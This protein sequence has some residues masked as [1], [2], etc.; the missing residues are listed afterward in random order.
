MS[1]ETFQSS[2]HAKT[3]VLFLE[4]KV[5]G[6]KNIFL[7]IAKNV[8]HNKNGKEIYKID[9]GGQ[10]ILAENGKKIINDETPDI[11]KA[12]NS[13]L[14][15]NLMAESHLGFIVPEEN[16]IENIYI[17]EV[18]KPEV[19]EKI[20]KIKDSK[21]YELLKFGDLVNAKIIQIKR[22]NE[23]GSQ[24]YGT[25]N[26][27]FIRTTDIVNWEV[28]M[29]TVKSISEEIYQKYKIS[30]D[31]QENDILFVND[32]T[33]L[34]GR[35]SMVTKNDIKAVIQSHL[36]KIRVI[37]EERLNPHYLFYLL[38]TE[39][40]QAQINTKIFTQATLSTLGNRIMEI[41][42]PFHQNKD[43]I[44]DLSKEIES[45]INQKTILRE[46]MKKLADIT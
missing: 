7:A 29:D 30:Q 40:V 36:R 24:H 17:P 5:H 45:I 4:K 14:N 28:K 21:A 25:G 10:Y 13:F 26:I 32:G 27:P 33:F 41:E 9:S 6:R 19:Q 37:N 46:R 38:N 42:L 1:Q 35:C 43:I 3:S 23:V 8:G 11:A 12:F 34:I 22:G 44:K 31:I 2:T 15:N 18:Y 16:I 20:N 39:I